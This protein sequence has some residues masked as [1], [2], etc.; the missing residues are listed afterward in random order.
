MEYM[1]ITE[2]AQKWGLS[3]KRVQV[4]CVDARIPGSQRI[5]KVWA[6]P[7][8]AVRP[9][10]RRKGPRQGRTAGGEASADPHAE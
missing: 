3:R 8:D 10:D 9:A 7:V 5:G 1:S 6:I 4:L 2:A